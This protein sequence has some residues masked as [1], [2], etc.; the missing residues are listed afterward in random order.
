MD[1]AATCATHLAGKAVGTPA[2]V[3]FSRK[4]PVSLQPGDVCKLEITGLGTLE[5]PVK[6]A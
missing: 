4:P 3:G 6:D 2:G 5:N 1:L